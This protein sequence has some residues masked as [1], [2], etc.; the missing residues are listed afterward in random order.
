MIVALTSAGVLA[1]YP[2]PM[3]RLVDLS[4]TVEH[5]MT[6]YPGLPGPVISDHLSREASRA[7]YEPGTEFHIGA[8]EMVGNT[9]TY[10][11]TPFHRFPDGL[12]LSGLPLDSVADLP[13]L[14]VRTTGSAI[15]P[16]ALDGLAL[17]GRAVLFATGWDRHWGT[18]RYGDPDHPY[19]T[20]ATVMRLAE[21]DAALVG[22][23][24]VNVDDTQT[25]SRP[26][27]TE[28]LR[29]G[30][31]LVEHLTGLEELVGA[32]F[33]FFAV[34]VKVKRMGTFPVRAFAILP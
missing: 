29:A 4:H 8:I 18:D 1:Q 12:D 17:R 34:P 22:T 30:I 23:D 28:L 11:D 5:G 14:C 21:G 24:A 31:P 15:E 33:R 9:G 25:G 32:D 19:L 3:G 7:H 26:A 10:I 2:G 20:A 13:G 6:T 16:D 27:H